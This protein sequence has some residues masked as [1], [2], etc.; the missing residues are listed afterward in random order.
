M[1][2]IVNKA[3]VQASTIT[4]HIQ[5]ACLASDDSVHLRTHLQ[6]L[7]SVLLATVPLN[8]DRRCLFTHDVQTIVGIHKETTLKSHGTGVMIEMVPVFSV[9]TPCYKRL[10]YIFS[11]ITK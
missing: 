7:V 5:L 11:Y 2:H 3:S 6:L 1:R 8:S 10:G 4:G 9:Q